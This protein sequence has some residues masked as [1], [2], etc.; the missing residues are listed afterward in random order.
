M[1]NLEGEPL[2]FINVSL[3]MTTKGEVTDKEGKYRIEN[4]EI[5]TYTILASCIGVNNVF[6]KT[7]WVGGYNYV[8]LFPG[9]PRNYLLSVG[10]TF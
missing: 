1:T 5:G 10:Y 4:V 9:A 6:D 3:D 2:E 8:R 7:H